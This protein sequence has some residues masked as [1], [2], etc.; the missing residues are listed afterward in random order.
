MVTHVGGGKIHLLPKTTKISV[1]DSIKLLVD[2]TLGKEPE[3]YPWRSAIRIPGLQEY[4]AEIKLKSNN[5][6]LIEKEIEDLKKKWRDRERYRDLFSKNDNKTPKAVQRILA[7]LGIKT[8]KTTPGYVID[9]ISE[10]VGVEVTSI[11]RKVNAKTKKINQL[12]RFVEE[13]RKEEKVVFVANT[14]NDLPIADR[15]T[16]EHITREMESFLRSIEVSFLTT[17]T[18]YQLWMKVI[19]KEMSAEEA[20]SLILEKKGVVRI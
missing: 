17:L 13:T 18:L 14:Y 3:E 12:T 19:T 16:K 8:R 6:D 5:I 4:E 1:S 9:L 10:K 7:D 20:S 2:L 11:K 15:M